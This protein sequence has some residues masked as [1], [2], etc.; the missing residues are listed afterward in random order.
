MVCLVFVLGCDKVPE[1]NASGGLIIKKD[2]V[3]DNKAIYE[4]AH[5]N[6]NCVGDVFV[7]STIRFCAP[8]SFARVGDYLVASNN[9]ITAVSGRK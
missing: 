6:D 5:D 9:T 1:F 2:L 7:D 4:L 8:N 3:K